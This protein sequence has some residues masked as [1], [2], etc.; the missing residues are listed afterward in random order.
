MDRCTLMVFVHNFSTYKYMKFI[1]QYQ[2]LK[3]HQIGTF[4]LGESTVQ[5][6]ESLAEIVKITMLLN[7]PYIV[8]YDIVMND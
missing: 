8:E 3:N 6:G 5:D 2:L 1:V 4:W 7:S